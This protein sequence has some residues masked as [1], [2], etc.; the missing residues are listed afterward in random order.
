MYDEEI[1]VKRDYIH[2]ERT[3]AVLLVRWLTDG[4][5]KE[6]TQLFRSEHDG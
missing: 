1:V 5:A 2:P 3:I 4:P 6:V